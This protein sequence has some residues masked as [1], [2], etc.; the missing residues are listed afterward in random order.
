[1][2][3]YQNLTDDEVLQLAVERDQLTDDAR[4]VLDSELT[5]R[6]L[7]EE[8]IRSH[9]ISYQRARKRDRAR[10]RHKLFNQDTFLRPRF[11][12]SFFGKRNL[13]R[14]LSGGFEDYETTR[15]FVLFWIPIFPVASFCVRR[16]RSRGLGM[17]CKGDP[18]VIDHRPKDWEQIL[19]T[20][21]K[22]A[23]VLLGLRLL[24]LIAKYHPEWIIRLFDWNLDPRRFLNF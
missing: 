12:L 2:P 15:W 23:S 22:V 4:L 24:Y 7:S 5:R 14:D 6:R 19:L 11:G 20:W 9:E 21:V 13:R 3:E 10:T 17:T 18:Q 1:M 8:D 16:I